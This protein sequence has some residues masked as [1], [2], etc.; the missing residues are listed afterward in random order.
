VQSRD[1]RHSALEGLLVG[2]MVY[3]VMRFLVPQSIDGNVRSL[4]GAAV[5][6]I[7][8][9]AVSRLGNTQRQ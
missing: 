2:A 6:F 1:W 7:A 9:M 5:A 3:V 8:S 4:I